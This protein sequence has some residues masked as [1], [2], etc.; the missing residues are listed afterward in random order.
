MTTKEL[1]TEMVDEWL[2][3]RPGR[4]ISMLARQSGVGETTLRRIQNA[5]G[6]PSLDVIV[7]I[8][9]ATGQRDKM[10]AAIETHYPN[11]VPVIA[12]SSMGAGPQPEGD[13]S[14]FFENSLS[15][16]LFLSLFTRD[17]LSRESIERDHG[18]KG[19]D[20]VDR[21]VEMGLARTEGGRVFSVEKWYSYRSPEELLRVMRNL[22]MEFEKS[23]IGSEFA[24]LSVLSES[25]NVAAASK[26]QSIIDEA[27][28]K[29][30]AVMDDPATAGDNVVS[31]SL[32]MQRVK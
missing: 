6:K 9:R 29:V 22:T 19:L 5:S 7:S 32:L 11:C 10:L 28:A 13:T 21:F 18:K 12:K 26:I 17:G 25:V 30:R 15:T 23:D 4:S 3:A 14:E 27:I 2:A 16:S 24:R 8:G 31:V 1:V 20:I